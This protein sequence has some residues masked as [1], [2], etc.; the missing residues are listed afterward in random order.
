MPN[1]GGLCFKVS[2]VVCLIETLTIFSDPR[3]YNTGFRSR[4][5][6]DQR[7]SLTEGLQDY[8]R[9]GCRLGTRTRPTQGYDLMSMHLRDCFTP[10]G[11][12]Q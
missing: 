12:S 5:S 4:W 2:D 1:P 11:G 10:Y 3:D 6:P 9:E 8:S 7:V